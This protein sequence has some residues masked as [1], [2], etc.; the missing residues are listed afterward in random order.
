ME[1]LDAVRVTTLVDNDVWKVGLRSSWGLSFY[2]EGFVRGKRRVVL[3]D[4]SGSFDVLLHNASLLDVDFSEVEAVFISHWHGDHCGSLNHVLPLIGKPTPVYVPS[5]NRRGIRAIRGTRG[6]P[7]VCSKPVRVMEGMMSTGRMGNWMGWTNEH[8]LLI[9]LRGRGLVILTGCSHPGIMNIIKHAK[10]VSGIDKVYGV[11]GGFHISGVNEGIRVAEFLRGLG[12][13]LVS[14]C[15]CT[16]ISAKTGI[17]K[18]MGDSYIKN[19]AG[20]IITISESEL[21]LL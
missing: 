13:R 19:G 20:R 21:S 5:E 9:N 15:H 2:V 4:T 11:I 3:M 17:M 6:V 7:F 12:V 18:I 16:H 14:P 10:R 8:S 1:E